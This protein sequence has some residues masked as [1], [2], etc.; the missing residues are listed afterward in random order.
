M[1]TLCASIAVTKNIGSIFWY[2]RIF[3]KISCLGSRIVGGLPANAGQFKFAAAIYITKTDGNYF[4]GG[5][6]MNNN[7]VLTAAQCVYQ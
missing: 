3:S 2:F 4:C 6:L 7:W 1:I 5:A